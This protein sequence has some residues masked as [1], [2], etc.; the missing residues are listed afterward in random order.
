[1][2]QGCK[3][4]AKLRATLK[5][6]GMTWIGYDH[7]SHVVIASTCRSGGI[8]ATAA[9]ELEAHRIAKMYREHGF[10]RVM[11]R[12]NIPATFKEVN[13]DLSDRFFS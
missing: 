5:E 8:E 12:P 7:A 11:V 4:E 3:G 13:D 9:T 6:R 1:M 10:Y 2:C